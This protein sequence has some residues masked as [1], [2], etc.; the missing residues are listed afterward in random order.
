[1]S[2]RREAAAFIAALVLFLCVSW[3][4][5][6][7]LMPVRTE[8]G[9]VW[10]S[11][12]Q[13]PEDSVDL[14]FCGSSIT[15]CDVIPALIWEE[16]GLSGYVMAGPEQTIPVTYYYVREAFRTQSPRLV[17][18]EATGMFFAE[19][20]NYTKA[21]IG[22]MPLGLNRL[23]ATFA[24][25]EREELWGLLFPLHNY[26]YRWQE[27]SLEEMEEHLRPGKDLTAG[28]TLLTESCGVPTLQQL[29]YSAETETYRE[30]LAYIAM[31]KEFCDGQGAELLLY[32]APSVSEAPEAAYE[33]LAGDL[34]ALGVAYADLRDVGE[35][36]GIDDESDWYDFL[37]YNLR[38]AEKF[39]RYL[40]GYIGDSYSLT[41]CGTD[42]GRWQERLDHIRQAVE[43]LK[44]EG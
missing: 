37:H 19:Y 31:L 2:K 1:M 15:Y 43:N 4:L 13:E 11:Y 9:G 5:G 36:I 44:A 10:E 39:T 38:G 27:V 33:T 21:N 14:L 34:E 40:A 25:A 23:G 17:V 7:L 26:H 3:V 29:D 12:R 20:K 41:P 24:G 22:Y 8:Y 6:W 30:N 28:Y 16:T 35:E 32:T 18:L 42:T